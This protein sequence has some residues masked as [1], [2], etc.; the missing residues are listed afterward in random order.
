MIE[1]AITKIL[2]MATPS[3]SE[4]AGQKF[5]NAKMTVLKP[6][7]RQCLECSTL[8]AVGDVI[9]GEEGCYVH[10]LTPTLV[11]VLNTMKDDWGRN[12]TEATVSIDRSGVTDNDW[13][14]AEEFTIQLQSKFKQT[15]ERDALLNLVSKVK[16]ESANDLEDDGVTQHTAVKKGLHLAEKKALPNP[17]TLQPWRTFSEVA[18]PPSLFVLRAREVDHSRGVS[19]LLFEAEGESWK[20]K[21]I[22]NIKEYLGEIVPK[23][24]QIIG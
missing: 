24:T 7:V 1:A 23:G 14:N 22:E 20:V 5:T 10:I 16:L 18:Q 15:K 4:V 19:F 3:Y 2:T 21:A 8:A 11:R 13:L 6:D 12:V 17:I 9:D